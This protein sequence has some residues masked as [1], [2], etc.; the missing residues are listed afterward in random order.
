MVYKYIIGHEKN[1][2]KEE[3][4]LCKIFLRVQRLLV[5]QLF[6]V[7]QNLTRLTNM[8]EEI[9]TGITKYNRI[10]NIKEIRKI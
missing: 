5:S 2:T 6:L 10:P 7:W 8:V 9:L 4:L 1:R 3:W